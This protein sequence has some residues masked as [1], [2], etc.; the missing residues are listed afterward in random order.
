VSFAHKNMFNL[1]CNILFLVKRIISKI[2][3]GKILNSAVAM[4]IVI[5]C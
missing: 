5:E 4:A 2:L 1:L 3:P